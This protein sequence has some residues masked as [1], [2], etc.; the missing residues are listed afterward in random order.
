MNVGGARHH[1]TPELGSRSRQV[2]FCWIVVG[3]T[4]LGNV[5]LAKPL[6]EGVCVCAGALRESVGA[7]A[8]CWPAVE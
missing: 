8:V 6:R 4:M 5:R 1:S 3:P 2:E 7:G